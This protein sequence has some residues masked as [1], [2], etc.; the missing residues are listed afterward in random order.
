MADVAVKQET[1][2]PAKREGIR[3]PFLALR[4]E[5]NR[6]F[7]DFFVG[8]WMQPFSRDSWPRLERALGMTFPVVDAAESEKEY[9]ITAELPGMTDKDVEVTLANGVLTLE[10]EKKEEREK[11]YHVSERRYGSFQRSFPLPEDVD[12]EGV[13]AKLKDGVFIVLLPRTGE[14][15]EDR[16]QGGL[17]RCRRAFQ[18]A[19]SRYRVRA[20][21][22]SGH[23]A[24]DRDQ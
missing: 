3:H 16:D 21:L 4:S 20:R 2:P 13:E 8:R 9:R 5:V 10:G 17:R 14:A 1:T 6:L 18:R 7:D 24:F 23:A 12:A 11:D 19:R 15:Q 22:V